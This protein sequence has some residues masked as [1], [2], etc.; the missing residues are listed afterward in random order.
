M[1]K[2]ITKNQHIVPQRHLKQFSIPEDVNKVEAFDCYCLKILAKKSSIK[3]MFWY[4]PSFVS[5]F[6]PCFRLYRFSDS[7]M[8]FDG[9]KASCPIPISEIERDKRTNKPL[10]M[11]SNRIF[12]IV[13]IRNPLPEQ[14]IL[15]AACTPWMAFREKRKAPLLWG[16]SSEACI[17]FFA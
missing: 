7:W 6:W 12:A 8:Y 5:G 13:N 10:I 9:S 3:S 11:N 15:Q 1:I 17:V 2:Q 14:G 4:C 16:R